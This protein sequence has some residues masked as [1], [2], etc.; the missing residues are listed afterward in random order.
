M[1][2]LKVVQYLVEFRATKF[3]EN[4]M[5]PG[6]LVKFVLGKTFVVYVYCMS[7]YFTDKI[8]G[9]QSLGQASQS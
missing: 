8:L 6:I 1:V 7:E 3:T 4:A 2:K 5:P 9:F